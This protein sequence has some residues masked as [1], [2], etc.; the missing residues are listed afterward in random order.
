MANNVAMKIGAWKLMFGDRFDCLCVY[1]N[2]RI[3]GGRIEHDLVVGSLTF[4]EIV[5]KP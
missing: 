5:E 3:F 1:G 2:M 4:Y